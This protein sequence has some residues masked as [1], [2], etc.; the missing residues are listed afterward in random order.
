MKK[1]LAIILLSISWLISISYGLWNA[2][3]TDLP[4]QAEWIKDSSK[5]VSET[6]KPLITD[7]W[8]FFYKTIKTFYWW[9]IWS[10]WAWFVYVQQLLNYILWLLWFIALVMLIYQFYL[11]FFDKEEEWIKAAQKAIKNIFIALVFIWLSWF[12]ITSIF[13]VLSRFK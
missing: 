7:E 9:N 3:S 11:I 13:Y 6:I 1:I 10:K 5:W 2:L 4:Y 12:I 8:W